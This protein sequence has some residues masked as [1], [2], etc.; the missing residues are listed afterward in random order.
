MEWLQSPLDNPDAQTATLPPAP[1]PQS[2]LLDDFAN[3]LT[4]ASPSPAPDAFARAWAFT[5]QHEGGFAAHDANNA[6]VNFG[7]NQA[8][9]PDVDVRALTLD[10][11]MQ[12]AKTR[13][14]DKSGA[15][16]LSPDLAAAHFDTFY[17]NPSVATRILQQSG[18]DPQRY[19]DLRQQWMQGLIAKDP[20][21]YGRFAH[22]WNTRNT[23]LRA[24]VTDAPGF[25][26]MASRF[27]QLGSSV[28]SATS[29]AADE[30]SSPGFLDAVGR[31]FS[32]G[33]DRTVTAD[34]S[35]ADIHAR[36]EAYQD[37]VDAVNKL[38]PAAQQVVNPML[39]QLPP[40]RPLGG[41]PPN[42]GLAQLWQRVAQVEREHPGALAN[43][44]TDE[45]SLT[46][47]ARS[48]QQIAIARSSEEAARD[49]PL[50]SITGNLLGSGA[51]SFEDPVNLLAMGMGAPGS[52]TL[53]RTFLTEGALNT[54]ADAIEMPQRFQRYHDLGEGDPSATDIAAELGGDFLL[55]GALPAGIKGLGHLVGH[56]DARFPDAGDNARAARNAVADMARRDADNP[57]TD[58]DVGR[59]TYRSDLARTAATADA[60]VP[61]P[62]AAPLPSGA[63][64]LD[65]ARE[66]DTR[67][68]GYQL[69]S[70]RTGDL[71]TD[72]SAMQYKR[73]GDE[74]GV[75]D[76]LKGVDVW[77]PAAAGT[78][79]V[80]ERNDGINIVAN[81]HQ[82][83]GLA[84]R[85]EAAGHPAIDHYALVRREA[86]GYDAQDMRVEAAL[87][88]IRQGTGEAIDAAQVLKNAPDRA[89][90]L[91]PKSALVK[92]ARD[93]GNLKGAAW[94]MAWNGAV[95]ERDAAMVGR[96]VSDE[97]MQ[98]ALLAYLAKAAP[99]T[100]EEAELTVRQALAAGAHTE[101]QTDLFG[102]MLKSNL[103][104]PE[105]VAILKSSMTQ[106]RRDRALFNT[107]VAKENAISDAGNVLNPEENARRELQARTVFTTL[108]ALA[109]R[110]G[111]VSDA[112]QAA[113]EGSLKSGDRRG[114]TR[115]FLADVRSRVEQGG[116]ELGRERDDLG[117]VDVASEEAAADAGDRAGGETGQ[118][119]GQSRAELDSANALARA[120][121]DAFA[122][123]AKREAFDQQTRDL[124]REL[125]PKEDVARE[126]AENAEKDSSATPREQSEF[127]D[128]APEVEALKALPQDVEIPDQDQ[129][130]L[131]GR[132]D[133]PLTLKAVAQEI[134]RDARA[135]ER[136]RGC[137]EGGT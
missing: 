35:T 104:L 101:T 105:R 88:N 70:F 118:P 78:M 95:N 84:R 116:V 64:A 8:A 126:G 19:M 56:F 132:E 114:S 110:K 6:P 108:K 26:G 65:S 55:G 10:S 15:A 122:D 124:A 86:D 7:I 12:L 69:Q 58:D 17:I 14:W 113:A 63:R 96:H 133:K 18:G 120:S 137:I 131:F 85:L 75:L 27:G 5:A 66:F 43:L 11:A 39:T 97:H 79:I 76:T 25:A 33:F 21:K 87:T 49:K 103:V 61:L 130:G 44:P 121:L 127:G 60:G 123:P 51:G 74:Q 23:D 4:R 106:L 30:I 67:R 112:L 109:E 54:G 20:A 42:R 38:V 22:A 98:T 13:Y 77:D 52:T 134:A 129:L 82:R 89:V 31:N 135:V 102:D 136:L 28:A 111:P 36:A 80:W 57:Y 29:N 45:G 3:T 48:L 46:Q 92:R 40:M 72:A 62:D 107:L 37:V 24:L 53:L 50:A 119:A 73:G 125:S 100:D 71:T 94:D 34:I 1:P 81:G 90:G 59:D 47:Y 83:L 115:A 91:P 9:N 16:G 99:A 128:A 93:L 68:Q 41:A 117:P 2:S 32:A